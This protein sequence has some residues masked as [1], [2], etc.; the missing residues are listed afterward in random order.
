MSAPSSIHSEPGTR[1]PSVTSDKSEAESQLS[2]FLGGRRMEGLLQA[3]ASEK[4]SGGF[5]R[6]FLNTTDNQVGNV[7]ESK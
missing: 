6:R 5:I 4:K 1:P 3:L 7:S 2:D